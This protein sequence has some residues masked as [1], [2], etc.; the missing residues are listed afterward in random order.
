MLCY[1]LLPVLCIY[2]PESRNVIAFCLTQ[3]HKATT[4]SRG[5]NRLLLKIQSTLLSHAARYPK[6][7]C[8]LEGSQASSLVLVV[9]KIHRWRWVWYWQG[10]SKYRGEFC[11]NATLSA[12]NLTWTNLWSNP[13][14]CSDRPA[15]NK[16]NRDT[17]FSLNSVARWY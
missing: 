7:H 12:T 14:L 6:Q 1:T 17:A 9:T 15:T 11:P 5:G 10:K 13:A 4:K 16:L 8:C 3:S 2:N